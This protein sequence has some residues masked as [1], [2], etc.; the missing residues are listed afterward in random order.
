MKPTIMILG[1]YHMDNP[2][3][4][5]VNF[6]ADDALAPKRQRELQQLVKQLTRFNPTK[7]AVEA[8]TSL[9]DEVN[10][11]YQDY[12][13]GIYKPGR[14]EGDQ[15]SLPLAKEMQHPKIYC[16]DW[17]GRSD[18]EKIVD[19]DAFAKTHN[20]SRLLEKADTRLQS[21]VQK[22]LA[23]LTELQKTGSV[24]D[25]LHFLNQ[26]ETIRVIHEINTLPQFTLAQIGIADQYIG[27]DWLL[28]WYERNLKI[29]VNLT[30]ITESDDDRI[31]LIIGA[32]HV[33]LVQHFL[34]ESGDYV[35]E[36]PLKYLK[37]KDAN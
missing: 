2:G 9:D 31:L 8:D 10:A 11:E 27:L 30:R 16:V 5:A 21:I 25:M 1:T 36:S 32:G 13:N 18:K 12:L 20:Q 28:G 23:T 3:A 15:V 37:L 26:E 34:E 29:F 19:V 22:P 6:E 14:S 17:F 7:I 24:I 33:Y 35:V 4:D